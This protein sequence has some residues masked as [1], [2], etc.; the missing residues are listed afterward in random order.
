MMARNRPDPTRHDLEK[1]ED[2]RLAAVAMRSTRAQRCLPRDPEGRAFDYRTE[3]QR[4]R[5]RIL[6]SRAFRRLRLKSHGG[7]TPPAEP[8]RDRMTHTL[9]VSQLARTVARSL[10]LN[11]DLVEA[12]A[13]GHELGSPP[14]GRA[15]EAALAGLLGTRA[16]GFASGAQSLRVVDRIE[17]WYRHPG[18]N[19]TDA[20]R[21]G[22]VKTMPKE[23][24]GAA[25][26]QIDA[27]G[28]ALE[29]LR[30]AWP[31]FFE[32]QVVAAVDEVAGVVQD[33]DD[34]LRA[35]A[36]DY[37][38]VT[39]LPIVAELN[40]KVPGTRGGRG[41]LHMKAGTLYRGLTHMLVAG[42]IQ[43]SRR[44]IE[45]WVRANNVV[46][47]EDFWKARGRVTRGVTLP[48]RTARMFAGL[49]EFIERRMHQG[50]ALRGVA[51]RARHIIAG[52]FNALAADPRLAED[53]LL[54]RFR[55]EN[56]GAYLRDL[57][58]RQAER[59][60]RQRYLGSH[61]FARLV[62]DH[63]AGMT[64]LFAIAEYERLLGPFAAAGAP[65]APPSR[66]RGPAR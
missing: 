42:L 48:A 29:Q 45:S 5:D 8:C 3:F 24:L 28:A 56:G 19:L 65:A 12:I 16:G 38:E 63:I 51:A 9:E 40:R 14:F 30:A 21:E 53:Y 46:V 47:H 36:L 64:D 20:V 39:R 1:D 66:T 58:G 50:A 57:T 22:I 18:L 35:G 10:S 17:K 27:E 2:Q 41:G 43:N 4:D 31:P 33:L 26:R 7:A 59:E 37:D 49:R 44:A 61:R 52:L 15:G 11:E 54:L 60:I 25:L 6:H 13:L 55:E 34:G 62:A 32:A 23:A